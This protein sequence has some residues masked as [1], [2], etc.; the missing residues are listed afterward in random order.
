MEESSCDTKNCIDSNS[1]NDEDESND[2]GEFLEI[3]EA[4]QNKHHSNTQ[5]IN[6][7]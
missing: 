3:T 4:K 2:R 1:V 7:K 6:T 5:Q